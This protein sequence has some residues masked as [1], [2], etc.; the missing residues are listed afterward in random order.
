MTR[1]Q[2]EKV[3]LQRLPYSDEECGDSNYVLGKNVGFKRG[4]IAGAKWRINSVWHDVSEKPEANRHY[5]VLY[6]FEGEML[7]KVEVDL[8]TISQE[9]WDL[10][11]S[12]KRVMSWAY[13]DDLL[14]ERKEEMK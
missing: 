9:I 4:F 11:V 5:L 6:R 8:F 10:Y 13:I 14:P 2:I 12:R 3:A 1:E 7:T